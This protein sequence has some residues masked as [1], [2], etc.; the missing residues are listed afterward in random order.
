MMLKSDKDGEIESLKAR[1]AKIESPLASTVPASESALA[2][3][4]TIGSVVTA[5]P[6]LVLA[7]FSWLQL[8]LP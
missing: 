6:A 2:I 5:V 4:A 3:A 7:P 8:P 1:I